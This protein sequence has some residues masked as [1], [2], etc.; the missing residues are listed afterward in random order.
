LA[1]TLR[2]PSGLSVP[3][4]LS[5]P[6]TSPE[7]ILSTYAKN[8]PNAA[9]L[10]REALFHVESDILIPGARALV[11]DG[12]VAGQ[13][14]ARV[15]CPISNA[16]VTTDGEEVLAKA[17]RI[18]MPDLITNA[19]GLIA[20]FAHHLGADISQTR[21]IICGII[22]RNLE[23]VFADSLE[24]E[25]PK[26]RAN[27]IALGRLSEIQKSEK[28]GTLRFLSPWI[29]TVGLSALLSG[30]KEYLSLKTGS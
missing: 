15:I 23:S 28:I 25:V 24:G 12:A 11:I 9:I 16:P 8:H 2:D 18:S 7:N 17:G 4:L 27:A 19:G 5:I 1:G 3:E 30:F 26:K 14:K 22:S 10:S 6:S 20:S 13:I 29:Q 21:K